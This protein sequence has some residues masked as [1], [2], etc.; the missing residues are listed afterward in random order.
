MR[1]NSHGEVPSCGRAG[2]GTRRAD[3]TGLADGALVELLG[4][5]QVDALGELYQRHGA[6][7]YRLARQVTANDALAEEAVQEAFLGM[8]RAPGGYRAV[9]GSVRT[10]LLGLA[11]H[12]AVDAVRRETAQQRRQQAQAAQRLVEPSGGDDPA[13]ITWRGMQ[14]AEVRAA[15]M[16]L[17]EP[18]RQV[19][20][21]AYFGG[22]TQNEIAALTNA[23]LGTVKTRTLAAMRRLRARLAPLR[24]LPAGGGHD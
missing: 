8:W 5:G 12:K 21:L 4:G 19:L 16:E 24:S 18:Q 23:P 17:P 3:L 1:T 2:S 13:A 9:R 15:V 22:Y 7:C 6:S 11:H 20:A 10:W 14:A